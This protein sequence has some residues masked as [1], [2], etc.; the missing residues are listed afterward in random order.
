MFYRN[1]TNKGKEARS[2]K[3]AKSARSKEENKLTRQEV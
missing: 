1:S 2:K 3:D